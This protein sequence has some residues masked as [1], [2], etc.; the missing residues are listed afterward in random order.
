MNL[1]LHELVDGMK[2]CKTGFSK[3]K[4]IHMIPLQ[5]D[6]LI[7]PLSKYKRPRF[8]SHSSGMLPNKSTRSLRHFY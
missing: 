1:T 2:Y 5:I 8:L 4:S 7:K 6:I 3:S